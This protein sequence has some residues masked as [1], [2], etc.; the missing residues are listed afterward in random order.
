MFFQGWQA[1]TVVTHKPHS[2]VWNR[3][4]VLELKRLFTPFTCPPA[5]L[6]VHTVRRLERG[7]RREER[8]ESREERGERREERGERREER[9]ERREER[10]EI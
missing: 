4:D 9:G 8:G 2:L 7:E 6:T 1:L 5:T 3:V 10:G